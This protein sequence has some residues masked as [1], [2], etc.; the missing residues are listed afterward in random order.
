[1]TPAMKSTVVFAGTILAFGFGLAS[2]P[3][4]ALA[5][6]AGAPYTNV[7]PSNDRGNNTGDSQ[8]EGL[9]ER[10]LDQNYWRNAQ[11]QGGVPNPPY[12][13]PQAAPR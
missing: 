13:A 10:Q 2:A 6:H 1:M 4:P 12:Y 5:A 3:R 7:D 11:R 8:V 9:N